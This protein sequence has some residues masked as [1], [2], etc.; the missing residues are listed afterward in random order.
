MIQENYNKIASHLEELGFEIFE[1]IEEGL[2]VKTA[3]KFVRDRIATR[4]V[5]KIF[6]PEH[7]A[8]IKHEGDRDHLNKIYLEYAEFDGQSPSETYMINDDTPL[9]KVIE[10]I[11]YFIN[12]LEQKGFIY[13]DTNE[14]IRLSY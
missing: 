14:L 3:T 8:S 13:G 1:S 11:N 10:K 2:P 6:T 4:V 7:L 9:N 12:E 5:I